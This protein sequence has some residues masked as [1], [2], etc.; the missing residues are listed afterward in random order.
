M[1]SAPFPRLSSCSMFFSLLATRPH[2]E[3]KDGEKHNDNENGKQMKTQ[4]GRLG[5]K[6]LAPELRNVAITLHVGHL[7]NDC[8]GSSGSIFSDFFGRPGRTLTRSSLDRRI[9]LERRTAEG[10]KV[11]V[12]RGKLTTALVAKGTGSRNGSSLFLLFRQHHPRN[13]YVMG[14]KFAQALR[15]DDSPIVH[16]YLLNRHIQN[17]TTMWTSQFHRS[18][19]FFTLSL[20]QRYTKTRPLQNETPFFQPL[21][22]K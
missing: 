15:T 20:P 11:Q 5:L 16:G 22:L 3:H 13:V 21:S 7:L 1:G 2:D 6:F 14:D 10:A 8:C 4:T 18:S 19:I 9:K 17:F 12:F